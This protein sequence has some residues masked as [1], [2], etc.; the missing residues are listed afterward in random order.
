M[1]D[2][3]P[4]PKCKKVPG[5]F[6]LSF[7]FEGQDADAWLHVKDKVGESGIDAKIKLRDV[8]NQFMQ[9]EG[10]T[11]FD[12]VLVADQHEG[13][14]LYQLSRSGLR[15]TEVK[16]FLEETT[17]TPETTVKKA[18][19][20]QPQENAKSANDAVKQPVHAPS[21]LLERSLSGTGYQVFIQPIQLSLLRGKG[22]G[23]EPEPGDEY[24]EWL[25]CGFVR[26]DRFF[27]ES[28]Q[29][30]YSVIEIL[31][32]LLLLAFLSLP[33]LKLPFITSRERLRRVDIVF[34]ALSLVT[35]VSVTTVFVLNSYFSLGAR[36][37]SGLQTSAG[38]PRNAA[39]SVC[40]A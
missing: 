6:Y 35:A 12:D 7:G 33:F 5:P 14:V 9:S 34:M 22:T 11:S 39:E 15:F 36:A 37:R 24:A 27:S 40:G 1:A 23:P 8:L 30:S 28:L 25:I 29:I 38:S 18:G 13:R 19:E 32:G 16:V 31:A 2:E 26:S 3:S 17:S 4:K 20:T 21:Q 10:N